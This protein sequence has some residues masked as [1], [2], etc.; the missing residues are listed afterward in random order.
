MKRSLA[1]VETT[2]VETD[3]PR[4]VTES[5]YRRIRNDIVWGRLQPDAPLRSDELRE[6]YDVGISPLREALTRLDAEG[7][8]TSVEQRGFRVA[9]VTANDV[10]DTMET[11]L[12]IEKPALAKSIQRGD[13]GWESA[14]VAGF[15]SLSRIEIPHGPGKDAEIWARHHRQFHMCLIAACGS[16]LQIELA[17]M[18]FD[19]AERHRVWALKLMLQTRSRQRRNIA[20]EHRKIY[21]AAVAR[22]AKAAVDALDYHYRTTADMVV[23]V[24]QSGT[25]RTRRAG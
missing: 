23:A 13:L 5:V 19:R 9:P 7:L 15:H 20:S 1:V 6:T 11:R 3:V 25:K 17:G 2:G 12:T 10:S 16:P 8:V 4:T 21:D 18:L 14:L 24:L 22:N